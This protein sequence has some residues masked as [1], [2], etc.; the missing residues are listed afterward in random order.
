[1]L[2]L[3][4]AIT[5]GDYK[6]LDITDR[7]LVSW[8]TMQDIGVTKESIL[9]IDKIGGDH[10]DSIVYAERQPNQWMLGSSFSG[11]QALPNLD[12]KR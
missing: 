12:L 1:M 4:M 6:G 5:V 3:Q 10:F 8:V 9:C 7:T 11:E 2:I